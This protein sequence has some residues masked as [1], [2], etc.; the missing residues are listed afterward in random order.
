MLLDIPREELIKMQ[1]EEIHNAAFERRIDVDEHKLNVLH[2]E[3]V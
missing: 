2:I 1:K 3:D